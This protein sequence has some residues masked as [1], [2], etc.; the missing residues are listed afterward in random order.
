M[1]Q[2]KKAIVVGASSGIGLKVAKLLIEQGWTVGVAA[3]RTE[4]LQGI[5]AA[6]IERIDLMENYI[7]IR[8]HE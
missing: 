8:K 1:K 6:A 5:G 3:R 7:W 2:G 4:L